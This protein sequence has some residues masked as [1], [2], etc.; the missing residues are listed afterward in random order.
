MRSK[1]VS[2]PGE[3]FAEEIKKREEQ[4][5]DGDQQK[6]TKSEHFLK[7]KYIK[8]NHIHHIKMGIHQKLV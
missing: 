7:E 2:V 5:R 8:R 6:P 3:N 1:L 4:S